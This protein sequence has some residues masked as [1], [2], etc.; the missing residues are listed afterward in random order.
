MHAVFDMH[1]R[2][3]IVVEANQKVGWDQQVS[4]Q[5]Q[6]KV[7]LELC[8]GYADKAKCLWVCCIPGRSSHDAQK[9]NAEDSHI[10]AVWGRAERSSIICV[11]DMLY[12]K[13]L[14]KSMWLKVELPMVLEIDN[15]GAVDL[16]NSFT[17]GGCTH[18]INIKQCFLR[19]LKESKHLID[20][21]ISGSE[22]NVDMFTKNSD[23]PL[24]KK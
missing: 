18:H 6:R 23:G 5:D 10:V 22:N 21:W 15:K 14:L 17:V 4:V 1:Q 8:K 12:A 16:I 2:C 24:F 3:R 20:N 7:G 11:Q 19:E 13:N 9:C